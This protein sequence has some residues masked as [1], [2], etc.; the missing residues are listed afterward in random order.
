MSDAEIL[1]I[2]VIGNGYIGKP[3]I[4]ALSKAGLKVRVANSR[5]PA[6]IDAETTEFGAQPVELRNVVDGADV[7]ILSVP[8]A[9]IAGLA[10]VIAGAP[11]TTIFVDTGNYYPHRDI[12]V[13]AIDE[14][15]VES[16]WV[17]EQLGR[18]IVKAWNAIGYQLLQTG[19]TPP[20]SPNRD[21]IPVA[22]DDEVAV[23][24]VMKLVDLTGFEPVYAGPL[25]Q[26]WRQQPGQPAYCTFL[27]ADKLQKALDAADEDF[28]R[29]RALAVERIASFGFHPTAAQ[30]RQINHETYLSD[31]P[32]LRA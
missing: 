12:R 28:A 18:P 5:G 24:T 22:G 9:S 6:S 25:A 10:P 17:S 16:V 13:D 20:G 32:E 3:V 7:V 2:G 23:R 15:Q 26:S 11:A 19:G 30:L 14:G 4:R 21:A 8:F 27:T 1:T 29:R 31:L